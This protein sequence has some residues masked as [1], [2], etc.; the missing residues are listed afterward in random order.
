MPGNSEN[1]RK[2]FISSPPLLAACCVLFVPPNHRLAANMVCPKCSLPVNCKTDLFIVC[3]G[4]C[5]RPFHAA[6]V[7]LSE[8]I[9]SVSCLKKNIIWLCD[10]CLAIFYQQW[11]C[12]EQSPTAEL[13]N[14]ADGG[15]TLETPDVVADLADIKGKIAN[16]METLSVIS[17]V[18][19]HSFQCTPRHSTPINSLVNSPTLNEGSRDDKSHDSTN[20]HYSSSSVSGRNSEETFSL[21]LTNID[22]RVTEEE[23]SD[24]VY[25]SLGVMENE[26]ITV[27]KLVPKWK[28]NESLEY[29]SFKVQVDSKF[30]SKALRTD[31]WPTGIMY[32]EF[33]HRSRNTWR[34]TG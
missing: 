9:V 8:D 28:S 11:R 10:E 1:L 24:M 14:V 23:I 33:I 7:G 20:V 30:K 22:S 2:V 3:E 29:I 31:I 25:R 27:K 34:P 5:C 4:N 15:S 13:S 21:F 17:E 12:K 16:I 19:K 26:A 6:C 18:Q 32:R